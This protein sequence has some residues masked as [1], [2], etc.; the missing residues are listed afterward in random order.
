MA[1]FF[2]RKNKQTPL[3]KDQVDL[4]R[5]VD[6]PGV[7]LIEFVGKGGAITQWAYWLKEDRDED[8]HQI[9]SELGGD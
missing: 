5:P 1:F 9:Q 2:S 6:S 4:V 8:L 7:Y 3:Q